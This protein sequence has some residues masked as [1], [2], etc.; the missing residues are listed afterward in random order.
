VRGGALQNNSE[1]HVSGLLHSIENPLNRLTAQVTHLAEMTQRLEEVS[2][3]Y[4][5]SGAGAGEQNLY[6][7]LLAARMR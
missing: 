1:V 3:C 2:H 6:V 7:Q 4:S 5:Q